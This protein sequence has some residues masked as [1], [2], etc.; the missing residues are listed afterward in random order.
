MEEIEKSAAEIRNKDKR[1][2]EGVCSLEQYVGTLIEFNEGSLLE[3][4]K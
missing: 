1:I 3:R 4:T 2:V